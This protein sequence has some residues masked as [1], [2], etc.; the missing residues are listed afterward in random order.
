MAKKLILKAC[1]PKLDYIFPLL[2]E[3]LILETAWL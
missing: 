3:L 2:L 1:T